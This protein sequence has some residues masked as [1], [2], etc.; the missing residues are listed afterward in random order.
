MSLFYIYYYIYSPLFTLLHLFTLRWSSWW[1][2]F[3]QVPIQATA[4]LNLPGKHGA[5]QQYHILHQ[6]DI[7][8]S[9]PLLLPSCTGR[10]HTVQ[11]ITCFSSDLPIH[12]FTSSGYF[13]EQIH[14]H[15]HRLVMQGPCTFQSKTFTLHI[16]FLSRALQ[17]RKNSPLGYVALC[18]SLCPYS[19]PGLC[20]NRPAL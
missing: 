11:S 2:P 9:S 13:T 3:Y 10:I 16:N 18:N 17:F 1:S 4:C 12:F 15:L 20:L 5:E 8:L 14:A 7:E 6:Q 19:I